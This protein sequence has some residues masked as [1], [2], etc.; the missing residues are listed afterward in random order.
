MLWT[1]VKLDLTQLLMAACMLLIMLSQPSRGV[2]LLEK[3]LGFLPHPRDRQ[4][5][6]RSTVSPLTKRF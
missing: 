6:M 2:N 5:Q 3:K 4:L 1:R